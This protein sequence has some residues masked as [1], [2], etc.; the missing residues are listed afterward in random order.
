MGAIDQGNI[1]RLQ[2]LTGAGDTHFL[3]VLHEQAQGDM[4][5]ALNLFLDFGSDP[6]AMMSVLAEHYTKR[7]KWELAEE[8]VTEGKTVRL[9]PWVKLHPDGGGP[10]RGA[11]GVVRSHERGVARVD[12]DGLAGW[13]VL[14]RELEVVRMRVE[15]ILHPAVGCVPFKAFS[16]RRALPPGTCVFRSYSARGHVSVI[17]PAAVPAAKGKGYVLYCGDGQALVHWVFRPRKDQR[18]CASYAWSA[19]SREISVAP[20]GHVLVGSRVER[21]RELWRGGRE[22]GGEGTLGT[23]TSWLVQGEVPKVEVAWD[24]GSTHTY[25]WDLAG[26]AFPILVRHDGGIFPGRKVRR[27]PRTWRWEDQDGGSGNVGMV[28][29][30]ADSSGWV[31]VKW[32][33]TGQKFEYRWGHESTYDLELLSWDPPP[34]PPRAGG[35]RQVSEDRPGVVGLDSP[36]GAFCSICH[37]DIDEPCFTECFHRFHRECLLEWCQRQQK[38]PIC[39]T[40]LSRVYIDSIKRQ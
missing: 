18:S 26:K 11:V 30:V 24:C 27:S 16:R 1:S 32:E 20:A 2:E 13:R 34:T 3:S 5:Y 22:D 25:A 29:S 23:V 38:C 40:D 10:R 15:S 31:K 33:R 9:R 28:T 17:D 35:P 14:T 21:N 36:E 4:R 37:E 6:S 7:D 12:F 8:S 19:E 39:Q